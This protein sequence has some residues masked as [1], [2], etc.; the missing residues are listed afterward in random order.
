MQLSLFTR[1]HEND[2][3]LLVRLANARGVTVYNLAR[4]ILTAWICEQRV[5]L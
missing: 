2:Y 3:A 5:S 1:L 4:Q